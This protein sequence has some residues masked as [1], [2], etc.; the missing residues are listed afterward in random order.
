MAIIIKS[1]QNQASK[2]R[3][4]QTKETAQKKE[5]KAKSKFIQLAMII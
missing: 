3:I 2:T 1:R 5:S 4:L